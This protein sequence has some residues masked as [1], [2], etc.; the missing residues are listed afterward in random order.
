MARRILVL[1]GPNLNLLGTREPEIYGSLTLAQI[2]EGLES[3]AAE[4]GVT[5][6]AW[7]SNHEGALVDRI[8]AAAHDGTDF[9]IINA[10]A[11]THTSVAVRD[12]LAGVAIPFIEVHLSNLYKRETFRHHSY[13]SD[14][15]IGLISGLG[16]NGY[17]AALRYAA[18]H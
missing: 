16:A 18:R 5:L 14:I 12:A 9:I 1:H 7:Q 2:N 11:Y 13:L 3:L 15:A 8:Q 17:E 6:S 4:L 10:A